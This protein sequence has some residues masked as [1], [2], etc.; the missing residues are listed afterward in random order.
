MRKAIYCAMFLTTVGVGAGAQ[1][2][3]YPHIRLSDGSWEDW[4][5]V[6]DLPVEK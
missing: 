5:A 3:A 4:S 1:S 2:P 6:P